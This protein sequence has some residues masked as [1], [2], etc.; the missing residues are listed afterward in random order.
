MADDASR[1]R[2]GELLRQDATGEWRQAT[3]NGC[4]WTLRILRED[5]AGRDEARLLFE[6]EIRRIERLD[7]PA[8]V[9]VHR[10]G[11]RPPR[12]WMLT[13][14]IDGQTLADSLAGGTSFALPKALALLREVHEGFR[15]LQERKQVHAAPWAT[16]AVRVGDGWK[17]LTFRGIRAWDEL[18]SLK[19]KKDPHPGLSPPERGRDHPA[20][21]KPEAWISWAMGTLLQA[22]LGAGAP[23]P[24]PQV[25]A[26]LRTAD[27][28][29]RPQGR[30]AVELALEGRV[31]QGPAPSAA[32]APRPAQAPVPRKRRGSR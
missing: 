19:G 32:P 21:L 12:P 31:P 2:I 7:H 20:P 27:P 10:V 13:D 17:F 26:S 28:D 8:L 15:Y 18:S 4:A 25:I 14:P 6:E 24:W 30:R 16:S 3:W 29:A 5:L 23:A 9:R 22:L 1:I 11:R